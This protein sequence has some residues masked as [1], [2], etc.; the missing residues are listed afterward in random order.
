MSLLAFVHKSLSNL[1]F[2]WSGPN[3]AHFFFRIW[4]DI[5]W[6]WNDTT[7]EESVWCCWRSTLRNSESVW[8]WV[9]T[10]LVW[11][12]CTEGV[13]DK[14]KQKQISVVVFLILHFILLNSFI[15]EQHSL[16]IR[17]WLQS[18]K[19]GSTTLCTNVARQR[20][21]PHEFPP[22]FSCW[23]VGLVTVHI[24]ISAGWSQA[25]I[26]RTVTNRIQRSCFLF[27]FTLPFKWLQT[28]VGHRL[29]GS[30]I[31]FLC[32]EERNISAWNINVTFST[33]IKQNI[34]E[35]KSHHEDGE[36][37]EFWWVRES[38]SS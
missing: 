7:Q 31:Y 38:M 21:W 16:V 27:P 33:E 15:N 5:L 10:P 3:F 25:G 12:G 24:T 13:R 36:I 20:L 8:V 26:R 18:F 19:D 17:F 34:L 2:L 14:K 28:S 37:Q 35:N 9:W 23:S 4:P 32:R 29:G 6:S 30:W 1:Y 22:F 11:V